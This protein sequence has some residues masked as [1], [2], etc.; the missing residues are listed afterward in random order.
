VSQREVLATEFWA[1]LSALDQTLEAQRVHQTQ[2]V[3]RL[4]KWQ[5]E[6]E[7][8]ASDAALTEENLKAKEQS[9]DRRETDLSRRETDL[10]F[11]EEML[12]RRG[13]L[14]VEH[15]LEAEEKEKKLEERI[16]QFQAA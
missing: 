10:V 11:R 16:W 5:Q 1:K 3:E 15:E 8:K 14:L 4:Q 13:K 6:L 7:G 2:A 12:T 9:L